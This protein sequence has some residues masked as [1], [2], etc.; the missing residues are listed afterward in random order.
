[1]IDPVTIYIFCFIVGLAIL[2][3]TFSMGMFGDIGG[4]DIGGHDVGNVDMSGASDLSSHDVS[5]SEAAVLS[6]LSPTMIALILTCFGAFGIILSEMDV[7]NLFIPAI[8]VLAAAGVA[9][10]VYLLMN[11]F[12]GKAQSSSTVKIEELVGTLGEVTTP[13]PAEGLGVVSLVAKGGRT[14]YSAK[15]AAPI[16]SGVT[17]RVKRISAQVLYVE[18]VKDED[19]VT[20]QK[21]ASASSGTSAT[22]PSKGKD[23]E[24]EL[25]SQSEVNEVAFERVKRKI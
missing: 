3:L 4:H 12:L 8:A 20:E 16:K 17:V 6:P 7:N 5:V 19:D 23:T 24:T 15:A 22:L 21:G 9:A 1:M 14:T 10:V 25:K 18:E 13:I 2:I 11:H